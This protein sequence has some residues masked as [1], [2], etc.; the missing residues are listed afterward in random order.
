MDKIEFGNMLDEITGYKWI[1]EF[2]VDNG[3]YNL[4]FILGTELIVEYYDKHSEYCHEEDKGRIKY[5]QEWLSNKFGEY[6]S[7]YRTPYI[8]V[9]NG[10]EYKAIREVLDILIGYETIDSFN[11]KVVRHDPIAIEDMK[12][13]MSHIQ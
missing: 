9:E 3:R 5:C 12:D 1:R 13:Y 7:N 6:G 4:D 2:P 8:R 11:Y 10:E